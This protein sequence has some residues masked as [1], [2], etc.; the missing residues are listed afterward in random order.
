MSA[1]RLTTPNPTT[2]RHGDQPGRGTWTTPG[3]GPAPRVPEECRRR[4]RT[5]FSSEGGR[6]PV[7]HR[8]RLGSRPVTDSGEQ[9][10]GRGAR[11]RMAALDVEALLVAVMD[12]AGTQPQLTVVPLH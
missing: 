1:A 2:G 3:E 7:H 8:R 12:A 10:G 5:R 11:R 9:D 4:V 6:L